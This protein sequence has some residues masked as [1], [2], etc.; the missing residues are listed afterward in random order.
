MQ[1]EYKE[2][3]DKVGKQQIHVEFKVGQVLYRV[4]KPEA[5]CNDQAFDNSNGLKLIKHQL[6]ISTQCLYSCTVF[7]GIQ[8]AIQ[9]VTGEAFSQIMSSFILTELLYLDKLDRNTLK[10]KNLSSRGIFLLCATAG[11]WHGGKQQRQK[12]I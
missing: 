2:S 5:D 11:T 4:A 8:Q 9:F 12:I 6:P 7:N 3:N 10:K 1:F